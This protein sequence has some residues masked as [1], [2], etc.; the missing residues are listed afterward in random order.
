MMSRRKTR[1]RAKG[2]AMPASDLPL[3][4]WAQTRALLH[5]PA[6]RHVVRRSHLSPALARTVA[7]L[8]GLG[9]KEA[10]HD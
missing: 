5:Q 7:E 2:G 10:C 3:F 4:A 1:L 6:V 9:P 8:A